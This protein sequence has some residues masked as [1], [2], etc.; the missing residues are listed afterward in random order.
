MKAAE[1]VDNW[2][3]TYCRA[4]CDASLSLAPS[5]RPG[6]R[7]IRLGYQSGQVNEAIRLQNMCSVWGFRP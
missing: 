4:G 5:E 1:P 7:G 2:L 3:D 6:S